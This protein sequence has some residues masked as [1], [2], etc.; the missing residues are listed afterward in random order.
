[1]TIFRYLCLV[2]S[3]FSV[4][5]HSINDNSLVVLEN[6]RDLLL[7]YNTAVALYGQEYAQTLQNQGLL[8]YPD[9]PQYAYI[10]SVSASRIRLWSDQGRVIPY[11]ISNS[12]LATVVQDALD[13]ISQNT[14]LIFQPRSNQRNYMNFVFSGNCGGVSFIG[15]IGGGQRVTIPTVSSCFNSLSIASG[16][17]QHEILHALGFAHQQS[18]P[19]RDQFVRI[20]TQNIQDTA[21]FN[22]EKRESNIIDTFNLPYDYKS[23]MHYES[24]TFSKNGGNTITKLDGTVPPG[25]F[26]GNQLTDL[27]IEKINRLYPYSDPTPKPTP[28][29]TPN[30]TLR[31]TQL[32]TPNLT[33]RPTPRATRFPTLRP[34]TTP[35]LRPTLPPTSSPDNSC[36]TIGQECVFPFRFRG[37]TYSSCTNNFD[38]DGKFWCSTR[39]DRNGVHIRGNWGYCEQSCR[40]SRSLNT[41]FLDYIDVDNER[42]L[43]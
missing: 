23:I 25:D 30:L 5:S 14:R 6:D 29:P 2:L 42:C 22:F 13:K 16:V 27:D 19:N 35:T 9:D 43:K 12:G 38:P 20:L 3:F 28:S 8:V 21:L 32:P 41:W 33:P 11:T 7:T 10:D 37:R 26:G 24:R 17:T 1:M 36:F 39:V 4:S 34:I 31:P 40:L 18:Y 15:M